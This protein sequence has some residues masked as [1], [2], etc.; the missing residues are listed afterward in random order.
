MARQFESVTIYFWC[1]CIITLHLYNI[2]TS[3]L[4]FESFPKYMIFISDIVGFMVTVEETLPTEVTIFPPPSTNFSL[5]FDQQKQFW[6]MR[7]DKILH[8]FP[9]QNSPT[10]LQMAYFLNALYTMF[11]SVTDKYNIFKVLNNINHV[12]KLLCFQETLNLP[13]SVRCPG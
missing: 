6:L 4:R 10:F 9:H 2:I 13:I 7:V 3:L 1:E 5:Q 11:D 8:L 12:L